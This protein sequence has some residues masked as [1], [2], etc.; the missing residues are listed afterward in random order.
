MKKF[1]KFILIILLIPVVVFIGAISFL[2]FADLNKY[3]PQ[4]EQIVQKYA[5][6]KIK[7]NGDLDIVVS[8]KPSMEMNNVL[9]YMPDNEKQLA[10]IGNAIIQISILPLIHK[11][12]VIDSVE[13]I[14]TKIFY[15]AK[16]N[17]LI[18]KMNISMEDYTSP[19]N[20]S[21]DTTV[22]SMNITGR[23][24]F[25]SFKELRDSNF[26]ETKALL[27][28]NVMGYQL[29][30]DGWLH[31]I[32]EKLVVEGDYGFN[33]KNN[34]ING[35]ITASLENE[36]PYINLNAKSDNLNVEDFTQ[37]KQA[38]NNRL[39]S[40]ALAVEYISGTTIPYDYLKM[41]DADVT[42]D[43]KNLKINP[44]ISVRNIKGI[45]NLKNGVFKTK[46]QNA[47]V[48]GLNLNG[49]VGVDSPKSKPY[50]KINIQGN[51]INLETLLKPSQSKKQ[52]FIYN[53]LINEAQ[54]S[55][56]MKNTAIPYEY[57][58]MV[59]VNA[60][61]SIKKLII[62]SDITLNNIM[63]DISINNGVLKN[64]IKSLNAGDGAVSGIITVNANTKSMAADLKGTD[65]ILQKLYKNFAN[66][67]NSE[68]YIKSGGKTNILIN[69]TA[70][71]KNTDQYLSSLSGKIIAFTDKS[72]INVKSLDRLRG[73]IIVQVLENLKLNITN[74]EMNMMCAVF[75]SDIKNGVMNFPKGIAFD[76]SDFYL[77][78]D[79][80]ISLSDEKINLAIQPFSGKIS[81][82]SISSILGGLLKIKGTIGQPKLALN[83]T[84]TAKNV[85]TAIASGGAYNVGDMMLSAD[86]APCHT[87]LKDTVYANYFKAD[88][89]VRGTVSKGYTGAKDTIKDVG[90]ELKNQ[91]K[92][93]K[94]QIK[95]LFK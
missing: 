30:F 88:N 45:S 58:S 52:A 73:N 82:T 10:D 21:Y 91:A 14:N 93:L 27:K 39:I 63:M 71:G 85:I 29:S 20:I 44:T 15:N 89:S 43:L 55:T 24:V 81:D 23:A 87:A 57:L 94:N 37:K 47:D 54:A 33:Y 40:A 38:Y 79:G 51:E 46:L 18:N 48:L 80:K 31:N 74:R 3:K 70:S 49:E 64:N 72:V 65:I 60:N 84:E 56:L 4:I 26:N 61:T 75:R 90:N 67:G 42:F 32:T 76:A 53:L 1:G 68:L 92:D 11:E 19:I 69:V 83:Q 5:N 12:V 95:S 41:V 50:A 7:I 62:N 36:V 22:S 8:L 9:V 59:N 28:S 2:K 66:A 34:D 35:K 16:D 17:V 13:T 78:A 25:S 77:V 86:A 6:V